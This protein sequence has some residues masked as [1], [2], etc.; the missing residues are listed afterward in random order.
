MFNVLVS[1]K[2]GADG[3][4]LL[5][6][7]DD[8]TVDLKPGLSPEELIEVIPNYDALVIRS[9]TQVTGD[10]LAAG[11]KLR[12]VG[13]AGV[14]VDNVEIDE[15]TRRGVIVMN[16]PDA[17][18][19]ATA[20]HAFALMM[21]AA[22]NIVPA[23]N[24]VAEGK[25][26][27]GALTGSELRGKT[28]GIVGFGRIGRTVAAR[29]QAFEMRVVAYDPFVSETAGR[30]ARVELLELDELL[31]TSDYITLHTAM[32]DDTKNMIN[33]ESLAKVKQG[34][35]LINAARGGLV[36]ADAVAASLDAGHLGM[37]AVDVYASEPP[38]QDHPLVG[39]PKV[40]HTPHLGAST[41][42]AQAG[43]AVEIAKQVLAALRDEEIINSVNMAFPPG[44]D[45]AR[46]NR[47]IELASKLGALQAA[48]VEDQI[49]QVEIELYADDAEE[50]MRPVA[51]G[52]LKGILA[53]AMQE[54][55][56]F[57]NS[58]L[59]AQERGIKISR[60]VGLGHADY[61]NQITCRVRWQGG[62][63]TMSGVVFSGD[64]PRI[65]QVSDYRLEANPVGTVL[66][67][68]NEDVPGV[69][70]A[71][72]NLLGE[73]GIN[74]GEWRLGRNADRGQALAFINL[75]ASPGPEV[76]EALR[77]LP[78]V[79]KATVVDL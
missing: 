32:S 71:V 28:L 65:V 10:V 43:V 41:Q 3:V 53:P 45:F 70:G 74:I 50:L 37:A 56:N 27:R 77:A 52:L 25:W 76:L 6:A 73:R 78:P 34:A 64:M 48:M 2:L 40:L 33:A 46:A 67:L 20:E 8:V 7:A 31:A 59:V 72:G 55:V 26:E 35:V 66:L 21:T 69:V 36:D 23:H 19:I 24:S 9:G 5:E 79:V 62:E 29:A 60:S 75:D 30:D 51:A 42:E 14:G 22:R 58:P 39:H 49:D 1:D 4:A 11:T 13:R 16:T 17:N 68:L 61:K 18:T 47:F 38:G 54:T 57:V 15:A 63:R 44:L 12:V